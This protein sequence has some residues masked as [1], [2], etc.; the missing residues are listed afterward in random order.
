MCSG[1][2]APRALRSSF[3]VVVPLTVV[4]WLHFPVHGLPLVLHSL[5]FKSC[6]ENDDDDDN[7]NNGIITIIII[8]II[9]IIIMMMMMMMMIMMIPIMIII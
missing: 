5:G 7:N 1:T 8:I 2:A 4:C 3:F 6:H 9:I